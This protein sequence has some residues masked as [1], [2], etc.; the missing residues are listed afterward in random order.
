[1]RHRSM[2][3]VAALLSGCAGSPEMDSTSPTARPS[4]EEAGAL[5]PDA[6]TAGMAEPDPET[7]EPST[8]GPGPCV[9]LDH[10]GRTYAVVRLGNL[11]WFAENLQADRFSNGDPLTYGRDSTEW[12]G[13]VGEPLYC[14]YRHESIHTDRYGLLYS[15]YAVTDPRGL[16]PSGW[17]VSTDADW[18]DLEVAIGTDPGTVGKPGN[19][20]TELK[21]LGVKAKS[22]VYWFKEAQGTDD[23]GIGITPAGSR[24][25]DARFMS[26]GS[27]ATIWTSTPNEGADDGPKQWYRGLGHP[28]TGIFRGSISP[29]FGFSVRCVHD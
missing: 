14:H 18:Q 10:Q 26:G 6:S 27:G 4:V 11:C 25:S 19:R 9:S 20:G 21:D 2:L 22:R 12:V 15:G 23:F 7:G 1:M 8:A 17:R 29:K 28:N 16:C 13:N 24:L 3:L 5:V